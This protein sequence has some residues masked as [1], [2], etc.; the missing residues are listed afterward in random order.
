[1]QEPSRPTGMHNA[2]AYV[3]IDGR[4][5]LRRL[6]D[7]EPVV[8]AADRFYQFPAF[9]PNGRYLAAIGGGRADG[10]LFVFALDGS[11]ALPPLLESRGGL[12]FYFYWAPDSFH[13][14]YLA[15]LPPRQELG[16]R[17]VSLRGEETAR[18]LAH[19]RPCFWQW[20]PSGAHI[21]LR[22]GFAGDREGQL[23]FIDPFATEDLRVER[24]LEA[25]GLFQ[26]PGIS[27]N[28]RHWA[29]ARINMGGTPEIVIDG[30]HM[31]EAVCVPHHGVAALAWSPTRDQLAW[32]APAAP[33]R[34]SYGPLRVMGL[35]GQPRELTRAMVLAFFWS[36]DGDRIAYFTLATARE[37]FLRL[38]GVRPVSDPG[39]RQTEPQ[40]PATRD[41]APIFL[42]LW[43]AD[44]SSGKTRL[45]YT[46]RPTDVFIGRV[47]PFFDQYAHSHPIWS[48]DSR[49]LILNELIGR[50]AAER[51][52]RPRASLT[53]ISA[54]PRQPP[55]NLGPGL[56]PA[57]CRI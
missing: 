20:S 28:G 56:M 35:D 24:D 29:Y 22:Q 2:L 9:S 19:G 17:L 49:H 4:L 55:R 1:M 21:L 15:G 51:G 30:L 32:I 10:G 46:F 5:L 52:S 8:V 47:L 27:P 53:L 33:A 34:A 23:A 16:L 12:P 18:L 3:G 42:N 45:A 43:I 57:W 37:D 13:L 6:D 31:E 48:P 50:K 26:S 38:P 40:A 14:T 44:V 36:P 11:E 25:P 41:G 54:D 39:G 7:A